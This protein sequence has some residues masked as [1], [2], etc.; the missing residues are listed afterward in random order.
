MTNFPTGKPHVS[1]SEVKIWKECSYRHKL[2]YIDKVDMFEPSPFLDFGTAVHEGCET[3]LTTKT[4][5]KKK[6]F[7]DITTAWDKYGFGESEWYEKMPGWD[8]GHITIDNNS[9]S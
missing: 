9:I 5:D 2:V 8:K 1:F 6:L 4:V 7:K 3:Y